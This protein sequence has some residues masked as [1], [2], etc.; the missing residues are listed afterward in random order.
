MRFCTRCGRP[1]EPETRF[2]RGCGLP[3]S[4]PAEQ[5][6]GEQIDTGAGTDLGAAGAVQPGGPAAYRAPEAPSPVWPS[7]AG[8]EAGGPDPAGPGP[9]GAARA[10]APG[11]AWASGPGPG[12]QDEITRPR[13]ARRKVPWVIAVTM[14]I[15]VAAA[16]VVVGI[17]LTSSHQPAKASAAAGA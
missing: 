8:P 9:A 1:I 14:A 12:S 17:R 15:V 2:C 10:G 16:G 7:Q 11:E 4:A 6:T 5:A 13:P 3:L